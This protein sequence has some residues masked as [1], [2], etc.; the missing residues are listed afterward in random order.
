MNKK[1]AFY[2]YSTASF[3]RQPLFYIT[4][5]LFTF[6]VFINYFFK[7]QF[8][9]AGTTDLL[10][11]FTSV[12][13]ISILAV[14]A[15]CLKNNFY[16]YDAFVPLKYLQKLIIRELS[17]LT[18]YA[19]LLL[20]LLPG[21]F[22]V[23]TF[24]SV[25]WGQVFTSYIMLLLYAAAVISLCTLISQFFENNAASFIV[26]AV[27]LAVF[28]TCHLFT[29]YVQLPDI[30]T[31]LFKQI[32]FAWHFD[33]ASKGIFD[34]R[35]LVW[36][37]VLTVLI[38]LASVLVRE[39]K[40]GKKNDSFENKLTK[41][42]I[43]TACIL[44]L[45]VS[46]KY[47][48]K[49]DFTKNKTYTM[50]SYT[51]KLVQKIDEPLKITF[52][53]SK[54]LAKLYPQVRDVNDFLIQFANQDKN[55]RL[56]VKNPDDDEEARTVLENFGVQSQQLRTIKNNSTEFINV[57]SAV[58]F[59]YD[60]TVALIPFVL[61]AESLE[62][63]IDNRLLYLFSKQQRVVN[64]I[65]GN[66]MSF[67]DED[68]FSL[69]IPWLNSQGFVCNVLDINSES[70]QDELISSHG[71]LL[72]LGDSEIGVQASITIE[73]YILSNNGNAFFALNPYSANITDDWSIF[74]NKR[75]NIVEMLENWGIYFTDQIAADISNSR[76]TMYSQEQTDD[77]LQSSTYTKLLNYPLWINV[78][79][80]K[81]CELGCTV[82]WATPLEFNTGYANTDNQSIL[83]PLLVSS[84]YAY[85]Y[86]L[87][88]DSPERLLETN[89]FVLENKSTANLE[90]G[91]K[92][93]GAKISGTLSGFYNLNSTDKAMIYVIPDQYFVNTLMT[94]YIGSDNGDYRN[95]EFLTKSLLELN[96]EVELSK[97]K[98]RQ[99]ADTSLYKIT[100]A[101]KF[102]RMQLICIL[103][104][105][106][107][108][109][110][111]IAGLGITGRKLL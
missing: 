39:K 107:M 28:N 33:S 5:V 17:I 18:V 79:P 72:V 111:L 15:L 3:F 21:V 19:L 58:V 74:P 70:F 104:L 68:G 16:D 98:A 84:P 52:Y 80:Q 22:V 53:R 50:S 109:P 87:D 11:F 45:I 78:L 10:M 69:V 77:Y 73:N 110:L 103:L 24:G 86:D 61:S 23:N 14:P 54:T 102:I 108:T 42:L 60:G 105:F 106:I 1:L 46:P 96:G 32:S 91:T 92:I 40:L 51:K 67:Y 56:V 101:A 9:A 2:K 35:D 38:V 4:A 97:L 82:F 12:P 62:Y 43:L 49:L 26:C 81:N 90:K 75:A 76:I 85:S 95:F 48:F 94:G 7:N 29:L 31:N 55:I 83:E 88:S 89:P 47:Y 8:F 27:I 59:E 13:Y 41:L 57:Y 36:F 63:D 64:L 30:I 99:K 34:L 44:T 66:G 93:L 20:L 100:D 25:D 71:P 37:G 65:S 6:F